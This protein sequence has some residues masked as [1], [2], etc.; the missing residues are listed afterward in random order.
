[1]ADPSSYRPAP[2]TI[3]TQP[4]VYRFSDAHGQVIYVGKAKN[5]RNRL[6]S[7]F[8][9]ISAL[10]P[11][12][13]R[14]VTTAAHVQWTVVQ[15]EVESLQLEYTWIKEFD[16]RFNVRTTRGGVI[17][18]L[19]ARP[20]RFATP[21]RPCCVYSRCALAR[22]EFSTARRT[23]DVPAYS[24]ISVSV[25][26]PALNG[27]H[28]RLIARSLTSSVISWPGGR[29]KLSSGLNPRWRRPLRTLNLNALR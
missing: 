23:R 3:P 8:Q 15:N 22:R 6:N 2:G 27:S 18:D 29:R 17:T 14:M 28:P 12:T 16:P 10:H 25:R 13:Q 19:L 26:L 7:Y 4:G 24:D 9:D 1:M 20:G 11:R 5:L 21:S